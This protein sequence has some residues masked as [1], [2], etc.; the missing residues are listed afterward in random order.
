MAACSANGPR[1]ATKRFV[2]ERQRLGNLGAIPPAAVLVLEHDEIAGLVDPGAAAR[3]VKQHQREERRRFRRRARRHQGPD[4]PGQADRL[5]AELAP[6]QRFPARGRVA[7]VEDEIDDRQHGVQPRRHVARVRNRIGN[8]GV[9]NLALRA[10]EPLRHRRR[11]N[12]KRPRDLVGVEAAERPQRKGHLRLERERGM[13]AGEDQPKPVVR[14]LARVGI[15]RLDDPRQLPRPVRF[16]LLRVARLPPQTVDGLVARRLD[17]PRSRVL[18]N[19]GCGP[20]L[21]RGRKCL[22]RRVFRDVEVA[23]E[24]DQGGDDVAPIGAID[25][26]HGRRRAEGHARW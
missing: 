16:E 2:D 7:F 26:V 18:R 4:E 8:S 22:L 21:H 20:L 15:R 23:D 25:L 11:R 6:H 9:A 10:H 14:D 17:Q 5:G 24:P 13:A 3:I 1:P 12:E 19:A